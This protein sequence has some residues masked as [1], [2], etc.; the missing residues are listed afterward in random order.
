MKGDQW[1]VAFTGGEPM[2]KAA[3][4]NQVAIMEH[5][6]MPKSITIETIQYNY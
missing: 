4:K 6:N 3:Q 2:L 5:L 1:H